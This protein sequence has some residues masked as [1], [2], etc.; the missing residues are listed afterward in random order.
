VSMSD[1]VSQLTTLVGS[2]VVRADAV[3]LQAYSR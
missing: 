3:S 2:D 1:L